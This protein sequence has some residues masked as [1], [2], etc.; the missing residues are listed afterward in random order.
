MENFKKNICFVI[1]GWV[2]KQTG[3]AERQCYLISEELVKRGWKVEVITD[4]P[5]N[6]NLINKKYLNESIKYIYLK[7]SFLDVITFIKVIKLLKKTKSYFYYIRTDARI[8]RGACVRYCRLLDKKIVYAIASNDDTLN[9]P[10]P[11]HHLK[12]HKST[13]GKMLRIINTI[14]I[15]LLVR[16][17]IYKVD[18]ILCQTVNQIKALKRNTGLKSI[19]LKNSFKLIN[20][21]AE[22]KKNII[23]WVGNVRLIK[24]YDIFLKLTQELDLKGWKFV[25]IGRD[26]D[27]VAKVNN[28]ENTN[29]KVLGQLS[30]EE[31]LNWFNKAKI[32]INTSNS[33]GFSNTFIQAW[34]YK[35]FVISLHFD[36]DY[37]L[38]RK[39]LGI[40]CKNDF[41]T[42]KKETEKAAKS[43]DEELVE[44]AY[45][46]ATKNFDLKRNVDK[47]ENIILSIR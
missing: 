20:L 43:I 7:R 39:G 15:E 12:R 23:L 8:M 19:L 36:P 18:Y 26:T 38:S 24:R 46:Y 34:F 41:E 35:V 33:E 11:T 5:K 25:A 14:T 37:L 27:L 45:F 16:K 47:F 40:Y 13:L 21:K 9:I 32:L 44:K 17:S 2:T 29:F 6:D 30:Y 42:L 3:G 22:R 10:I 31:T 28:Q 1:P 4:K